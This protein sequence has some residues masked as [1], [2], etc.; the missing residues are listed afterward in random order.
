MWELDCEE[1]WVPKNWCFWTVVLE[2]TLMLGGIG[3]R[4]RRGWQRMRWLYGIT[5]SMNMTL[6][7]LQELVMDREAWRALIHGVANIRT[8]LSDWT[9][10]KLNTWKDAQHHS[11]AE[12]CK[13]KPQWGAISCQSE[14]LLSKSLQ[15]VNAGKGV[16]KREPSYTLGGMQTSTATMENSVEIP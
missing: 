12:K 4:S 15:A 14:W 6:S 16:E 3:G 5:D 10:L 7:E 8:W 1:G 9:E 11:L 2:K 13:S